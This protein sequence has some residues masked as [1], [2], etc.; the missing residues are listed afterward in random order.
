MFFNG[1]WSFQFYQF[2][3]FANYAFGLN[4]MEFCDSVKQKPL[5]AI[6]TIENNRVCIALSYFGDTECCWLQERG[7]TLL[8]SDY[9]IFQLPKKF[10]VATASSD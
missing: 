9:H 7:F 8:E 5:E 6:K 3:F 10:T 4:I 1:T 2:A